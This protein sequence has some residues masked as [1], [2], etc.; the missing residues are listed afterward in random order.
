MLIVGWA[1]YGVYVMMVWVV[2]V[3]VCDDDVGSLCVMVWVLR[4]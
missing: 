2:C 3:C 1:G 4:V